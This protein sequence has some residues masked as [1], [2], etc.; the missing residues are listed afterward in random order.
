VKFEQTSPALPLPSE[1]PWEY[2]YR[3]LHGDGSVDYFDATGKPIEHD[4]L[5]GNHIYYSYASGGGGPRDFLLDYIEDSWSQKVQFRYQPGSQMIII[6]PDGATTNLSWSSQGVL[7][8]ED[9]VGLTTRLQYGSSPA[10]GKDILTQITYPTSL[11]SQFFYDRIEY[12]D[13]NGARQYM[14]AVQSHRLVDSSESNPARTT[15][16]ARTDYRYGSLSSGSTYTGSAVGCKLVGLRD[17]LIEGSA[18]FS[19]YT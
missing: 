5:F 10:G 16:L 14:P 7:S 18:R 2:S 6:M 3:L 4:D 8:I 11:V 17:D 19:G 9:P 13:R 12:L 1:K 15:M